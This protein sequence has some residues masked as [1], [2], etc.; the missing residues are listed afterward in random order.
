MGNLPTNTDRDYTS[1]PPD[2]YK[3]KRSFYNIS[4]TNNPVF[5]GFEPIPNLGIPLEDGNIDHKT[6]FDD[7]YS[8]LLV[9]HTNLCMRILLL[10]FL[11][12]F[13]LLVLTKIVFLL[14][15]EWLKRYH[16]VLM[17]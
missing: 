5:T 16:A 7:N 12:N 2:Y 11:Q 6:K 3:R 15:I 13:T 4:S 10:D 9:E 14:K 1:I 17:V 8:N